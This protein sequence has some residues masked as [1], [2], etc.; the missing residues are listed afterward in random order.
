ESQKCIDEGK[1]ALKEEEIVIYHPREGEK[2]IIEDWK[3]EG[4]KEFFDI[5]EIFEKQ[6]GDLEN[7]EGEAEEQEIN[8]LEKT[9]LKLRE[10]AENLGIDAKELE[11]A[12]VQTALDSLAGNEKLIIQLSNAYQNLSNNQNS[13]KEE[14]YDNAD[15]F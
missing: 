5:V 11:N 9:V 6:I 1:E 13:R 3:E 12:I 8:E 7:K 14:K 4:R 2:K 15:E 10:S